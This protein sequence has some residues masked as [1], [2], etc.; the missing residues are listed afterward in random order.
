MPVIPAGRPFCPSLSILPDVFPSCPSFFLSVW[1]GLRGCWKGLRGRWESLRGSGESLRDNS[2]GLRGN[3]EGLIGSWEGCERE[4]RGKRYRRGEG[5][6]IE[7][8]RKWRKKK[9]WK[10][11][12][13]NSLSSIGHR[14]AEGRCPKT[15]VIQTYQTWIVGGSFE[16]LLILLC[17]FL[18]H[19]IVIQS[20]SMVWSPCKLTTTLLLIISPLHLIFYVKEAL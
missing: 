18:H 19:S 6:D 13:P 4:G 1:E 3:S 10:K 11:D 8:Y 12:S 16:T 14:P 5:N 20:H 2:E 17:V 9:V 7:W 15:K